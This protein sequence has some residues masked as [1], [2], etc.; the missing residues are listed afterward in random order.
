VSVGADREVVIP[1]EGM[2]CAGCVA[3]VDQALLGAPGV[4]SA[5]VNLAL[6]QARVVLGARDR[7]EP[8]VKAIEDAGYH[9]AASV[10][11]LGA[12]AAAEEGERA[13]A[14]E[15]RSLT[16]RAAVALV[17]AVATMALS[18][19]WVLF[20][21]T[22]PVVLWCGQGFFVRAWSALRHGTANMSTLVAAGTGAAF[23]F[24]V[25]A[26][27]VPEAFER[28]GLV[29][30]VYYDTV[31]FI[32][33]LV[34][35]G[36]A[37]EARARARTSSAIRTLIGL[38]P[39]TA[40][41]VRDGAEVTVDVAAVRL[42]DVVLVHPG[43]RVP[44]DGRVLEGESTVD[45]SMLTG[46]PMPVDKRAGE[47]VVGGTVN[48]YGALRLEAERLGADTVLAHIV[49]LVR[50]A[51]STR[52]PIQA[53]ADR[54]SAV[55]VPV[56]LLVALATFA[57]WDLFGPEPRLLH[58]LVAFVT[59]TVIACPCAMGLA[60]PTALIVGM[61]RGA[62]LGVLVRSGEALQRAA[63]V[64]TVVLDKT[65][66]ITEGKPLL[67]EIVVKD[68]APGGF[69]LD[70]QAVLALAAAVEA[71]SEHPIA[72]AI[73]AAAR[74]AGS[75]VKRA[76]EFAAIPGGGAR[77]N[78]DGK[79]VAVGTLRWLKAEG[80]NIDGIASATASVAATGAT[81]VILAVHGEGVAVLAI[82]DT[83]RAG[84]RQAVKRLRSMGLRVVMLTGDRRESAEEVAREVG[85]D[86][87][88]AEL[89]PHDK[90]AAIDALRA[91]GRSVA[92]VGDGIN[93]A[94]AL[95]HASVGIAVGSGTD[96]ALQAADVLLLRGGLDGVPI[97]L[98]L[99]RRTLH[100]IRENLFWAFAYNVLGIPIAA[101]VLYPAFGI[102][103]S[104]V[105]AS[106]AMAMSS[107]SVVVNSLRLK[108][109]RG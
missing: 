43:E 35:L 38:A 72:T 20:A 78:V 82:R 85:I 31:C 102:L 89:S 19:R 12:G 27:A 108:R 56:V 25:V 33:G 18:S 22:L 80:V 69:L 74:A 90:L 92:M 29:P 55:F 37:L 101:G 34:L 47:R 67:A 42:G 97:V 71:S 23:A 52:A 94:P 2:T 21:L 93:D 59:V 8:L 76:T 81:P 65:G 30:H 26:T 28:N 75:V 36:S 103:L 57:A 60:T 1:I 11:A 9:S 48:G 95:A 83:V 62:R 100:T 73:G 61:G 87:V 17:L 106:F 107:V 63:S 14:E 77:G 91:E 109:F 51:Q 88:Q 99:A 13:E 86:L 44:V 10:E 66:T 6:R 39:R 105:L 32:I 68:A 15:R 45:E 5:E 53:L 54:V 104:P 41:V 64:D 98:A 96:V 50:H 40:V 49:E 79:P 84:A 58:A 4:R 46:E 3:R 7:L 24:S 16:R 70:G